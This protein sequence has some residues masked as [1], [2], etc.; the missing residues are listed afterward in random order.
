[1]TAVSRDPEEEFMGEVFEAKERATEKRARPKTI[2]SSSWDRALATV[3]EMAAKEDYAGARALHFVALHSI[4]F[5]AVY[6]FESAELTP[7]TRMA[8]CGMASC[9][10]KQVFGEDPS[11]FAAYLRW[12]WGREE[13]R[14]KWRREK[15][16][17]GKMIGWR[18]VFGRSLLDEYAL[19]VRRRGS[20]K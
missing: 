5:E 20:R 3:R 1:M 7:A 18:L 11:K 6:G 16:V 2:A 10:L 17:G 12:V 14:E 15:K 19:D 9:L 13:E 4:L 8:A